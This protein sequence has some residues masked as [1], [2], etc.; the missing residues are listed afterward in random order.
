MNQECI[1]FTPQFSRCRSSA[2]YAFYIS[3]YTGKLKQ[4]R[5]NCGYRDRGETF[6]CM[7]YCSLCDMHPTVRI[8]YKVLPG[9]GGGSGAESGVPGLAPA[10]P[11][12][13]Q[14]PGRPPLPLHPLLHPLPATLIPQCNRYSAAPAPPSLL[15]GPG[16]PPCR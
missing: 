9:R 10:P 14:G 8:Y 1:L 3:F 12:L 7:L 2:I 15:Q 11:S 16:H 6:V 4:E 5:H 13:I